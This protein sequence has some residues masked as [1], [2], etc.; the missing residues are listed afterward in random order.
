M[1]RRDWERE[2]Q[3]AWVICV[4]LATIGAAILIAFILWSKTQ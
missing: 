2:I 1:Q 3:I 4:C